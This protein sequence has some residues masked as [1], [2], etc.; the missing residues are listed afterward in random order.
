MSWKNSKDLNSH[1]NVHNEVLN[2]MK[3]KD[4]LSGLYRERTD[5]RWPC[6][7][8]GS[9]APCADELTLAYLFSLVT[10]VSFSYLLT[11]AD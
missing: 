3:S 6:H 7:S 9:G 1:F 11:L 2:L 5:F 8:K 10:S 4:L